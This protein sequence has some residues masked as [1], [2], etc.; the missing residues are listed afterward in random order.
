MSTLFKIC[1]GIAAGLEFIF[2]PWFL[3]AS[4][5]G[6]CTKSQILQTICET[7]F[8]EEGIIARSI[9]TKRHD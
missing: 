7:L 9:D 1:F 4:R 6:R 2:V 8:V 5:N 3:K